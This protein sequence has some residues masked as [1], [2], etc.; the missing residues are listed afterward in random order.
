MAEFKNIAKNAKSA[1]LILAGLSSK[2]KNEA[3]EDY[4]NDQ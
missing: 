2:K 3:L 4:I 1:S